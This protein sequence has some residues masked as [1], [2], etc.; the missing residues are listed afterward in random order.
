MDNQTLEHLGL[1]HNDITHYGMNFLQEA[2][3]SPQSSLLSLDISQNPIG[4][5][6]LNTISSLF[7]NH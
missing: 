6:G 1:S 5:T 3:Q 7:E 2:L 4:N